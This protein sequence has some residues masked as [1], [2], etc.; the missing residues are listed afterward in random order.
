[1]GQILSPQEIEQR[2]T[3]AE[4]R[5]TY[6]LA[7]RA[8]K[9]LIFVSALLLSF[10]L[11]ML[12][13]K[14]EERPVS[15][16]VQH[17]RKA[18]LLLPLLGFAGWYVGKFT[19]PR[20]RLFHFSSASLIWVYSFWETTSAIPSV[21]A[22]GLI[23]ALG[24][25]YIATAWFFVKFRKTY[26]LSSIASL[27][28]ILVGSV[29]IMASLRSFDLI[30]LAWNMNFVSLFIYMFVVIYREKHGVDSQSLILNPF[31][32]IRGILWPYSTRILADDDLER[33]KL[34]WRGCYNFLFALILFWTRLFIDDAFYV[35]YVLGDIAYFNIV[36][37]SARLFGIAVPDATRFCLLARTPAEFWRR[38]NVYNYAFISEFIFFPLLRRFRLPVLVMLISF[39]FFF[40]SHFS[41]GLLVWWLTESGFMTTNPQPHRWL[42]MFSISIFVMWL[43]AILLS[44]RLWPVPYRQGSSALREWSSV[45]LTQALFVL[46]LYVATVVSGYF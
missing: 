32:G 35:G 6:F 18:L 24:P 17:H 30:D 10:L 5:L 38:G 21:A 13:Q 20:Q 9:W 40:I 25:I 39:S 36:A 42:A 41:Y 22:R 26:P 28:G 45:L 3:E 15:V 31:H 8:S 37:G 46:I 2:W 33:A 27:L 16:V 4:D 23:L 12:G 19:I 11:E 29:L 14:L 34:W 43:G 1:M 7:H 44:G